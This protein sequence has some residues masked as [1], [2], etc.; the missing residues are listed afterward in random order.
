MPTPEQ[1]KNCG[2]A[3]G[4]KLPV[5]GNGHGKVRK[6][7]AAKWRAGVLVAVHVLMAIHIVQ[8][9]VQGLTVSPV[10]PS[11]SMYAL[12]AGELNA[13]FIFFAL[14]IVSTLVFGRYFCGWGCH[15]I[16]VQDACTWVMEKCGVRPRPLRSRVLL[17]APLALAI[18]MFVFPTFRREVLHPAWRFG[19]RQAAAAFIERHAPEH[20]ALLEPVIRSARQPLP[21]WLG[22]ARPFP[23]WRDAIIVEDYWATFA[24][25]YVAI[26]FILACG[27]G[28]VYFLGNKG[29]CTY[30][31]PYGGFFGVADKF[32]VGRIVVNDRCNGCGHCTAVCTSNVRVHQEVRDYGMVVS[33]G[34]MKTN[35]CISVCPN[36]ALSFKFAKPAIFAKPRTEEARTGKVRGPEYDLPLA[37]D[38]AI[39]LVGL[40]L[41]WAF[42]GM[43]NQ[44]PM[45]MAVALGGIGAFLT[46]KLVPLARTPNVRLQNLQLRVKGRVTLAGWI[47]VTLSIAYLGAGVWSGYVRGLRVAAD[48]LDGRVTTPELIVFSPGYE[49]DPAQAAIARRAADFFR[50][51]DAP[52]EGGIGWSVTPNNLTRMAWLR[53]VAGD[54]PAAEAALRRGMLMGGANE[55]VVIGL[56]S[57]MMLQGKPDSE[58]VAA[59]DAVL[60]ARPESD[61]VRTARAFSRV[62]QGDGQGARAEFVHVFERG[63]HA[64]ENALARAADGLVQLHEVAEAALRL[65]R[66][67]K[68]R[69]HTVLLRQRRAGVALIQNEPDKAVGLLREAVKL[70][71]R[72]PEVRYGLAQVLDAAGKNAEARAV[73]SE[74]NE[75]QRRLANW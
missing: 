18:Y 71:P 30:G 66:A 22:E 46:W 61:N 21:W 12:E 29:F 28:A 10:E 7:R 20:A 57:I 63:R 43:F 47:V 51:S 8:W 3:R 69:P 6:S 68:Q 45:L 15:I 2:Q 4:L 64:D 74:A 13:G 49:P 73:W 65:D 9:L 1:A 50:R 27:A 75:I 56:R 55:E 58:F 42:R 32:A 37:G 35:D 53:A 5:I 72:D 31:C 67:I 19:T 39:A 41:F 11:E 40:A 48:R 54:L 14:A 23:G 25:W 24:P 34:C 36:D 52:G 17:W 16:A 62:R 70:R 33:P 26:P 44:V 38:I 59:L 60:E